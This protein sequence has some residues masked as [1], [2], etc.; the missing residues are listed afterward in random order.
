LGK[1]SFADYAANAMKFAETINLVLNQ[2]DIG[3]TSEKKT[4]IFHSKRTL[5]ETRLL[6]LALHL[7]FDGIVM[8]DPYGTIF[9]VNKATLE[10]YGSTDY[11]DFVGKHILDFI[12]KKEHE[13][14]LKL[15]LESMRTGQGYVSEFT[16]IRKDG[17]EIP[18]EVAT[19]V[20][21]ENGENI[22]FIDI[23]RNISERKRVEQAL[24]TAEQKLRKIYD[25]VFDVITYVDTRGKI[26][27]VN[28]RVEDLIGYKQEEV[29]GRYFAALNL[30]SLTQLPKLLKLFTKTV[31]N[32]KAIEI[33]ELDLK[34]KDGR[35]VPV[36]VSTRFIKDNAGKTVG[37][38]NIFRDVTERKRAELA[39][40]ESKA[41]IEAANEKLRVIGSLTRHDVR[42]KLMVAKGNSYLLRKRLSGQHDLVQFVDSIELAINQSEQIFEFNRLYEK[43]GE[44][45]LLIVDVGECFNQ[46]VALMPSFDKITLTNQ[47]QGL[48]ILADKSLTQ[49]FHTLLDNSIRHGQKVNE[50]KLYF[51]ET[52]SKVTIFY[53]DNGVGISLENKSRIFK[54][55]FSTSKSTGLGLFLTKKILEGYG[56]EIQET[57]TS[58]KGVCFSITIPKKA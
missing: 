41:K 20:V 18:V 40:K 39:L 12:A 4:K 11:N 25:N 24:A 9:Y 22:G 53:E 13:K 54:E 30:V 46:A 3:Q 47:C 1:Q 58:N 36:E 28:G 29:I 27:D 34:H 19:A 32:G 26:L 2:N 43:I 44:E 52:D 6:S 48:K 10:I 23:V 45:E 37:V 33:I 42:N 14:A 49:V 17:S 51:I 8:G 31:R 50:I 35:K 7:S 21:K 56:W 55:G 16:G 57:G 38:V 5:T 15:S